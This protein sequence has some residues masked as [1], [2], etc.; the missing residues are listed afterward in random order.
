MV[1]ITLYQPDTPGQINPRVIQ[2]WDLEI[3]DRNVSL[4]GILIPDMES[5]VNLSKVFNLFG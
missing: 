3:K 2:V 4:Q 5:D 1:A